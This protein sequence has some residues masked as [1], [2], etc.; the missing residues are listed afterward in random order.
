M[1][2]KPCLEHEAERRF[3]RAPEAREPRLGDDPAEA[4]FAGLSIREKRLDDHPGAAGRERVSDSTRRADRTLSAVEAIDMAD[5]IVFAP[6]ELRRRDVERDAI[7]NS[8][9][10]G[11][12]PRELDRPEVR[13]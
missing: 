11:A 9:L 7:R 12:P 8:G 5:E 4:R 1:W 3:G 10:G 13:V 2:L 6:R